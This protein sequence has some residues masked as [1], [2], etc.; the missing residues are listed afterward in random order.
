MKNFLNFNLKALLNRNRV[1]L[2]D[3]GVFCAFLEILL[4]KHNFTKIMRLYQ[5]NLVK[6]SLAD[7][8]APYLSFLVLL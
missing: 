6:C 3:M 2:I 8:S 7:K 1:R 4:S 5:L